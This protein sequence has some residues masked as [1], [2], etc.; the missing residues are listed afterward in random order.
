MSA[1]P[2]IRKNLLGATELQSKP[3]ELRDL[4]NPLY[5]DKINLRPRYQRH[6]RWTVDMICAAPNTVMNNGFIPGVVMYQLHPHDK[7]E[8]E[9]KYNYEVIDGQHRL[10]SLNAFK[11]S[12]LIKLPHIP[13]PFIVNWKHELYDENGNK[14][15]QRVFYRDTPEVHAWYRATYKEGAPFFL[16]EEEKEYFDNYTIGNTVIRSPL[17]MDNRREIFMSLQNG[18]PVRNSDYLK[19]MMSCNLIAY[20]DRNG[21]EGI[22]TTLLQFCTKDA[23]SYWVQ[24]AARKFRLFKES[25]L[26]EPDPAKIFLEDDSKITKLI[27]D[28]SPI[29]NCTPEEFAEFD[30]KMRESIEFMQNLEE[31]IR[32]NPTQLNAI[33]CRFF[34]GNVNVHILETHMSLFSKDGQKKEN[35]SLWKNIGTTEQRK[36]YFNACLMQLEDMT[37]PARPIDARQ[38]TP[39]LRKQVYEKAV[40]DEC[41]ICC[42]KITLATF[43]ASHIIARA[44]SG[45]TELDNLIPLC[46]CCNR[47]MGTLHPDEYK[48]KR[49][50]N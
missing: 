38:I 15:I 6:I 44:R 35:K 19:N 40:N 12:S 11:S 31:G 28:N 50:Y 25:K 48:K 39:K 27:K 24:W 32:F 21:Y 34:K 30:E 2:R 9:G 1:P 14:H 16:T 5:F 42:K 37:Y 26:S 10:F 43:E 8:Y 13:K 7:N 18:V 47:E 23:K 49:L 45:L 20:F 29:L 4:L 3:K 22:M 36:S 17:S 33:S 41:D 46:R